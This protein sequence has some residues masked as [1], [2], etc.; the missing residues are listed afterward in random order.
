MASLREQFLEAEE[1]RNK[2]RNNGEFLFKYV[3]ERLRP[4]LEQ[5]IQQDFSDRGPAPPLVGREPTANNRAIADA[6]MQHSRKFL[7]II[8][9]DDT[10]SIEDIQKLPAY[11]KLHAACAHP[12]VDMK[13]EIRDDFRSMMQFATARSDEDMEKARHRFIQITLSEP[14]SA[15]PDAGIHLQTRNR[16]KQRTAAPGGGTT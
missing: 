9:P 14:Y 3:E 10:A 1:K 5:C 2:D 11:K 7:E 4:D 16:T 6:L 12:D 15:S 13:V 8:L